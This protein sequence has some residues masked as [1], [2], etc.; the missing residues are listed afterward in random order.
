[1]EQ[2]KEVQRGAAI[3]NKPVL[4]VYDLIVVRLSNS[5]V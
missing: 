4:A 3:Y 2:D 5:Y 1:M